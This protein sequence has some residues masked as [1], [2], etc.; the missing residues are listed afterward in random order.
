MSQ[1]KQWLTIQ[2]G[3]VWCLHETSVI[4]EIL[5]FIAPVGVAG[6]PEFVSGIINYRSEILTLID[7]SSI[8]HLNYT[9]PTHDQKIITYE[10]NHGIYGLKV[11][12]VG[13]ILNVTEDIIEQSES[14]LDDPY[15]LII[16][17]VEINDQIFCAIDIPTFIHNYLTFNKSD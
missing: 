17:S 14:P 6:A 8:L 9:N 3:E 10:I 15:K 16:G 13:E 7:A 2:I 4:R 5:D 1:T 11:D 12:G